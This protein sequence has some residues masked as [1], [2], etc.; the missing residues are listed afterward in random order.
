MSEYEVQQVDADQFDLVRR[1]FSAERATRHCWC[2][3]FCSTSRQFARGWYGGGNRRRFE[4]LAR[5]AQAPMGVLATLDGEPVGWCACGPRT[6][7]L[8]AIAGRSG[9]LAQRPRSEDQQV[10]LVACMIVR[11]D[12]RGSGVV[13]PLVRGAVSLARGNGASAIEAWPLAVGVRRSGDLH[14]GREGAFAR[15]GFTCIQRPNAE[16][17]IMRLDLSG[18]S[19][20]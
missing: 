18:E 17:A 15:F 13:G 14:V 12:H 4:E 19:M 5:G 11:P 10:W 3:A 20:P 6:R 8:I 1:L 2:V 9:L 16:R 7:Y